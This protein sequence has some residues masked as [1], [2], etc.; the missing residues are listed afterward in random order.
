M[1]LEAEVESK[2]Y[3][4]ILSVLGKRGFTIDGVRFDEPK[5]QFPVN[6]RKA[7][8]VVLLAGSKPLLVIE[9]DG[10]YEAVSSQRQF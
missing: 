1:G 3:H 10:E 4:Y 2:L 6:G 7:D 5:T 9:C 8:L